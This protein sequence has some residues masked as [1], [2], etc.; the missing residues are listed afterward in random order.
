MLGLGHGLIEK[1]LETDGVTRTGTELAAVLTENKA[2]S[3]VLEPGWGVILCLLVIMHPTHALS[4]AEERSEVR[5]LPIIDHIDDTVGIESVE[6]VIKCSQ[7]RS[8]VAITTVAL[9]DNKWR[10]ALAIVRLNADNGRTVIDLCDP[11]VKSTLD[12]LR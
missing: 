3:D 1:V 2:E 4:G 8:I 7:V 12:D 9:T 6:T 11:S 10:N 5:A